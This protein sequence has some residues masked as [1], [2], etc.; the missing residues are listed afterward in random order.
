MTLPL[1]F[2]AVDTPDVDRA[3][4][5]AAAMQRA[6]CGIKLG[7]EFFNAQGAEG[8]KEIRRSY[9]DI[10]L[11]LDLKFH[12]IPNTVAGAVRAVCALEPQFLNVHASGGAAMMRAARE[13]VDKA[14]ENFGIIAPKL[15]GVTILTSIDEAALTEAGFQPGLEDRVVQL[16]RLTQDTGLDGIVCSGQEIEPVRRACGKDFSLMVPGIRPDKGTAQDQKRVMTPQQALQAGANYLVIGR[17]ITE[18]DRPA[19][20]AMAILK[21][22]ET[23]SIETIRTV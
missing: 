1:I 14:A 5:L 18:A 6:G 21:T 3:L 22:I 9:P 12:D 10:A 11:F 20:A 4:S 16:A 17:P 2:C 23:D 13:A 19:E 7:L 15:L 8:V